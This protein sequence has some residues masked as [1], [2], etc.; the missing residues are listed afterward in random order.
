MKLFGRK[1]LSKEM[2][3]LVVIIVALLIL[4]LGFGYCLRFTY[5][6]GMEVGKWVEIDSYD[7]IFKSELF[8]VIEDYIVKK[9]N[10]NNKPFFDYK[11]M[12]EDPNSKHQPDNI[13][14]IDDKLHFINPSS[15]QIFENTPSI[16]DVDEKHDVN[17]LQSSEW[18][19]QGKSDVY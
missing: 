13:R 18:Y 19:S 5:L 10:K 17:Y 9:D 15:I 11:K 16:I 6:E 1:G 8:K 12:L 7:V 4:C 14:I 3:Y 2:K